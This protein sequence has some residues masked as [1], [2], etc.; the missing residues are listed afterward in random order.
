M[1]TMNS[2]QPL[3]FFLGRFLISAVFLWAATEKIFNWKTTQ[4]YL[5]AK[6]VPFS[7]ALLPLAVAM[8]L[9]GGFSLLFNYHIRLGTFLLIVFLIP[10]AIKMH[11]FWTVSGEERAIEKTLFMKD[12]A[13]LGGL[14]FLLAH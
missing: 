7:R 2:L 1:A 13:I 3:F 14:L 5:Q 6:R 12:V 11:G 9:F 10:A 4:V 8:Q